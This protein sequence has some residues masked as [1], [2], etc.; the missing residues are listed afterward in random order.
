[1]EFSASK[2]CCS[3][4]VFSLVVFSGNRRVFLFA[5]SA[6]IQVKTD[7]VVFWLKEVVSFKG[8]QQVAFVARIV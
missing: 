2:K 4:A 5:F 6:A 1:M 8:S 7:T 3:L